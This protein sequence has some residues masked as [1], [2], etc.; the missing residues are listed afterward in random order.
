M[1][2]PLVLFVE[3]CRRF[4]K[5]ASVENHCPK[6]TDVEFFSVEHLLAAHGENTDV[7]PD[8]LWEILGSENTQRQQ[9][10]SNSCTIF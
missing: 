8:I 4:S 10:T 6:L 1:V 9:R 2:Q 7:L 5:T 3:T